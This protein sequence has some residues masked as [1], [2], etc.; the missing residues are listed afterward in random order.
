MRKVLINQKC[1][2]N[3]VF[4]AKNVVLNFLNIVLNRFYV[5]QKNYLCFFCNFVVINKPINTAIKTTSELKI[6]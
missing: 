2:F 5:N 3:A 4:K 6:T 1:R